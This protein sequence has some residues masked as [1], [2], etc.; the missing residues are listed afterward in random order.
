M[1]VIG[2]GLPRQTFNEH[3]VA[4]KRLVPQERLLVFEP[5]RFTLGRETGPLAQSRWSRFLQLLSE[6]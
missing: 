6:G 1:K 5:A 4:V 2:A 3:N